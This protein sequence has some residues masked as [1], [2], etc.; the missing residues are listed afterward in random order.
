MHS[1]IFTDYIYVQ[2]C[3]NKHKFTYIT[4]KTHSVI[5]GVSPPWNIDLT[6]FYL[7]L[8]KNS[9]SARTPLW[10]NP[11][12]FWRTWL[13][14]W[15]VPSPKKSKDSFFKETKI[16]FFYKKITT[17]YKRWN[18]NIKLQNMKI[19]GVRFLLSMLFLLGS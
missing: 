4:E 7:G 6:P 10:A 1:Q 9:E 5:L 3:E 13:P 12:K 15:N 8:L 17:H 2:M 16:L 18:M 11:S 19:T 14:P